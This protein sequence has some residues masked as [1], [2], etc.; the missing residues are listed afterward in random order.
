MEGELEL[1]DDTEARP[2]ASHGPE[3][4]L[5]LLSAR[6]HELA[7]GGDHRHGAQ[8]VGG[9]PELALQPARAGAQ[10]ET[11]HADGREP[12]ARHGETVALRRGVDL[13][14]RRAALDAGAAP[15]GIDLDAAHRREVDDERAIVDREPVG[16]VAA[17]ADRDRQPLAPCVP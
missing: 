10:R 11:G 8:R 16:P 3:Q 5:M 14:P 7:V 12:R 15:D 13:P 2:T 4:V 6:P 1:D 9:Q 17:T